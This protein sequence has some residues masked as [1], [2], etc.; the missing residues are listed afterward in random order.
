[1]GHGQVLHLPLL[2]IEAPFPF[3]HPEGAVA[4]MEIGAPVIFCAMGQRPPG[5]ALRQTV[6]LQMMVH[7]LGGMGFSFFRVHAIPV[8]LFPPQERIQQESLQSKNQRIVRR[9]KILEV[10]GAG[11]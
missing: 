5:A 3:R 9:M 4:G 6:K 7:I 2:E 8:L 10:H 1:M 11:R